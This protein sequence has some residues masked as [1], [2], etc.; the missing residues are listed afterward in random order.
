MFETS[1]INVVRSWE[2]KLEIEDEMRKAQRLSPFEELPG[3]FPLVQKERKSF[4]A[5]IFNTER[6]TQPV[7]VYH[8]YSQECCRE[9]Q[10]G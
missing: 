3:D 8:C 7:V 6:K 4:F 1:M 5:R 9:T 10:A 2:R